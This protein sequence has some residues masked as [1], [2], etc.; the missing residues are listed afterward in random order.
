MIISP[1]LLREQISARILAMLK[2]AKEKS[3][4]LEKEILMTSWKSPKN[5]QVYTITGIEYFSNTDVNIVIHDSE[6]TRYTTHINTLNVEDTYAVYQGLSTI[7][8]VTPSSY[9]ETIEEQ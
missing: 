9:I 1:Q 6:E 7:I 3:V 4:E 5:N 2:K 8:T